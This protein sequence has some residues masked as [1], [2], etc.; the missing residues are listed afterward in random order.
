MLAIRTAQR[1]IHDTFV[2]IEVVISDYSNA[3]VPVDQFFVVH[4]DRITGDATVYHQG[5]TIKTA[6]NLS[7]NVTPS[8]VQAFAI[9]AVVSLA[10]NISA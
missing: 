4:I 9:C 6:H 3:A 7:H 8:D 1:E 5:R 2:G 10:F